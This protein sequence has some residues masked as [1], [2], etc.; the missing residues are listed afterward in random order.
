MVDVAVYFFGAFFVLSI[1]LGIGLLYKGWNVRQLRRFVEDTPTST[2]DSVAL[3]LAEVTGTAQ[4]AYETLSSPLEDEP[5]LLYRYVAYEYEPNP[6]S[7]SMN[8][9]WIESASATL[10]VP[11]MLEGENGQVFVDPTDADVR[12][13]DKFGGG[14]NEDE[15]RSGT[16]QEVLNQYLRQFGERVERLPPNAVSWT[17][18]EGPPEK[19]HSLLSGSGKYGE[20]R[21]DSSRASETDS[22]LT[23]LERL[24][25]GTDERF[26]VTVTRIEPGDKLYILGEAKAPDAESVPDD[27]TAI[28]EAPGSSQSASSRGSGPS[29]FVIS[30]KGERALV[31]GTKKKE[32]AFRFIGA[33]SIIAGLALLYNLLQ[34]LNVL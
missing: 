20:H 6:E 25:M 12:F 16:P 18:S 21:I 4:E 33:A 1:L 17:E 29:P 23:P 26:A 19:V 5:S 28:F 24:Q 13:S 32:M 31:W 11:F 30:A 7:S 8:E 9:C 10:G 2:P 14:G 3:G 15:D 22:G 27:V 34:E